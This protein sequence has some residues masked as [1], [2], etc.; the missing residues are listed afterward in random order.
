MGSTAELQSVIEAHAESRREL[1]RALQTSRS[2]R[3]TER[4]E[5]LYLTILKYRELTASLNAKL[6]ELEHAGNDNTGPL[7]RALRASAD[8]V[9]RVAQL[10]GAPPPAAS[11]FDW[12][13]APT[14]PRELK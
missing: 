8:Q 14:V 11:E 2:R 1:G 7:R 10:V 5:A 13:D 12:L 3:T 6:D 9:E 4:F